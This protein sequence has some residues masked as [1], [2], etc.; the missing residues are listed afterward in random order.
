MGWSTHWAFLQPQYNCF[1][2][3]RG[4]LAA[5]G[6]IAVQTQLASFVP[7]CFE[8]DGGGRID[9]PTENEG[10]ERAYM[11]CYSMWDWE[12]GSLFDHPI[13]EGVDQ[14]R[15]RHL[16]T[17]NTGSMEEDSRLTKINGM[18]NYPIGTTALQ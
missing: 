6:Y 15:S 3:G 16:L 14:A 5:C 4:R 17:P 11:L 7:W 1:P 18:G 2:D 9:G 12:T 8:L 13:G 10:L